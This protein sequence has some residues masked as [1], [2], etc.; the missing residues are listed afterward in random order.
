MTDTLTVLKELLAA[1]ETEC[2]GKPLAIEHVR[3]CPSCAAKVVLKSFSIPIAEELV[4]SQEALAGINPWVFSDT[5]GDKWVCISCEERV[6]LL[7]VT[8]DQHNADCA[9]AAALRLGGL[10]K[11]MESR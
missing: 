11:A 8:K 10:A 7:D 3:D 9:Y 1:A 5:M 4:A 2:T 6:E